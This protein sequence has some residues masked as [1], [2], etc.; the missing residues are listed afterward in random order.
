M[1]KSSKIISLFAISFLFYQ[2]STSKLS[3]NNQILTIQK[4]SFLTGY[5][6]AIATSA[7]PVWCEASAIGFDGQK[8]FMAIDKDMPNDLTAVFSWNSTEDFLAEKQPENVATKAFKSATK[9]EDMAF[10]PDGKITFLSSAF[11]RV[12][13]GSKE[14]DGFNTIFYWATGQES[15]PQ[16]LSLEDSAKNSVSLRPILSK[17][18]RN[19][20]FPNGMPYFKVEGFAISD[21]HLYFAVREEGKK[22]DDFKY[23]CK[24][25]AVEYYTQWKNGVPKISFSGDFSLVNTFVPESVDNTLTSPS[26][27]ASIEYD[28]FHKRFYLLTT[29]EKGENIGAYI[30]V[31][32]EDEILKNKPYTLLKDTEGK[33]I[34]LNHKAEDIAVLSANKIVVVCDDDRLVTEIKGI[35]RQPNQAAYYVL[36]V[37]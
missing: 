13:E 24:I 3:T 7:K 23:I 4:E 25:I 33:A 32:T 22:Y 30:W 14:W 6:L 20:D 8:V 21:T 35:K 37:K 17:V 19:V 1:N 29:Y 36:E 10:T 2:C 9:Y 27:V 11:D 28:H 16:V 26:G 18:L 34:N 5:D 12:E 31:A 15:N